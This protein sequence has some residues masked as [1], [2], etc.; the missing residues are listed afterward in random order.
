M[1]FASPAR[2]ARRPFLR[3]ALAALASAAAAAAMVAACGG[4]GTVADL[5]L[6]NGN[7][8]TVDPQDTSAQGVAVKDGRIVAVGTDAA[9][10]AY[11]G[12]GTRVIDLAGRT[13]VPGLYDAHSHFSFAGS[14]AFM[15]DLNSPPIGSVQTMD[16]LVELL[17]A[18]KEKMPAGAWITG[19][20][21]D[22][23]LIVEQRHPTR[24]D[25]DRVS[26]TQPVYITHVSGHLSVA[27]SAALALAGITAATPNPAGGVIRK[28]AGGEPDGVLEETAANLVARVNPPLTPAQVQEGIRL[29]DRMYAAQGVTTANEGAASAAGV[30]SLEQAATEGRLRIRVVAWPMKETMEAAGQV[31]LKSGKVKVAGVKDFADG[32]IQ[33]YTG[34]LSEHYHAPFHGDEDYRGFPRY[35]REVLAQRIVDIHQTG[36]QVIVHGNGDAAIDDILYGF[37]KAQQAHPRADARPVVIHSQMMRDDQLDELRRLGGIPSFFSLHTYYWGDRHR[38][39]FMGPQRAARMSPAKSALER[40]IRFT[41]HADT[42]VVPMEPMRLIWSAV[43]RV[44]TG[45]SVIGAAQRITPLQAL[46]A[47]TLDAAYQNFEEKERGSIE[48]GKW[49][50]FAILSNDLLS[51]DPMAIKDVRVLETILEG[52]TVYRAPD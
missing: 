34:Y 39:I 25:L 1:T 19:F 9:M 29:A 2:K 46:R 7:V 52:R 6:R 12:D 32:S 49:A 17:K 18:Q 20:G 5:V 3:S 10:A 37:A 30:T 13:V 27:N 11:I 35:D 51:I 33:G 26:A 50:D 14:R 48:V 22:D 40:G 41:I 16:Q 8:V 38:D 42:P 21:Y 15:A 4:G 36:R 24:A 47:T 28:D 43:N 31:A 44:S 23:T 45:G